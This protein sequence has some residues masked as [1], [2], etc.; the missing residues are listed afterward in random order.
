MRVRDLELSQPYFRSKYVIFVLIFHLT[1]Q[2]I[3]LLPNKMSEIYPVQ[4][5]RKTVPYFDL[6]QIKEM[7]SNSLFQTKKVLKPSR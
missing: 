6:F 4:F 7:K 1:G 3:F 2:N 5:N